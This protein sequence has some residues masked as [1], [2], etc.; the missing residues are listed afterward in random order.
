M[1]LAK[2]I[3]LRGISQ[4]EAAEQLGVSKSAMNYWCS[5]TQIPRPA[6]MRRIVE[7]S[8]GA[9]MPNDFYFGAS[10]GSNEEG[11]KTGR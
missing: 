6:D 1:Q 11:S 3:E 7:W 2:Y 10:N 8:N 5:G 9:V 4:R